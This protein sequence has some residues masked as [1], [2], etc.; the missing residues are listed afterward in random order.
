MNN[1]LR[2]IVS[3]LCRLL[4]AIALLLG[5]LA[6]AEMLGAGFAEGDN[7]SDSLVFPVTVGCILV[8]FFLHIIIHECGHLVAG[9]LSDYQFLSFRVLKI[10]LVRNRQ[11]HYS[12][13][14]YTLPG[15]LGQCLLVPPHQFLPESVP[16][17][18]YNAGGITANLLTSVVAF[19]VLT[20]GKTS[21]LAYFFLLCF[22]WMGLLMALANGIPHRSTS[23]WNDGMNL[24]ELRRDKGL[25]VHFYNQLTI[26][27]LL[28]YGQRYREMPQWLFPS[29]QNMDYSNPLLLAAKLNE[30][31]RLE[32]EGQYLKAHSMIEEVWEHK[33]ALPQGLVNDIK[34][35]YLLLELLTLRRPSVEAALCDRRLQRYLR[36]AGTWSASRMALQYALALIVGHNTSRARTLRVKFEVRAPGFVYQGEVPTAR[37][38]MDYVK[39]GYA[40][41]LR[42]NVVL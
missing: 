3:P 17:F 2:Q 8:A 34:S 23:I 40:K 5:I 30:I 11:G 28:T 18:W 20:C 32:D 4:A 42:Q 27:A 14:R 21:P 19:A 10:T 33:M 25:R 15:T 31:S 12:I 38:Q 29:V 6:A 9:L 41:W 39:A 16:Y 1:T 22:V 26:N 24:R 7:I 13:R 37:A 35:E 36:T